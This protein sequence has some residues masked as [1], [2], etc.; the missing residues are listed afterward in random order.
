MVEGKRN[1]LGEVEERKSWQ[2]GK[3]E[4]NDG[5]VRAEQSRCNKVPI[6]LG[7]NSVEYSIVM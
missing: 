5:E 4:T 7:S 2:L 3:G 6:E 1:Q